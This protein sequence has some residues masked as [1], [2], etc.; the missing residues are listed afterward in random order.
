MGM[1]WRFLKV[2]YSL[3]RFLLL[4]GVALDIFAVSVFQ[5]AS[6]A[7]AATPRQ[8]PRVSAFQTTSFQIY[9]P[10]LSSESSGTT[11][12]VVSPPIAGGADPVINALGDI[13]ACSSKYNNRDGQL[14]TAALLGQLDGPILGLGDYV[15]SNGSPTYYAN[16][17]DPVWG[18]LKPRFYPAVGNHDY[19]TSKAAGYFGYFGAAAGDPSLGYYSFDL[20]QWHIVALNSNCNQLDSVNEC[21]AGSAQELWLRA[22]LAAHA[23]LCT[24]AF[25]HHPLY[26]SGKEGNAPRMHDIYQALI[27]YH[28]ELVINGH[29]HTYERFAPQD[30]N[31][32]PDPVNGIPEFVVGTGG[33]DHGRLVNLQPNSLI[34]DNTT[35]GVLRVVLHPDGYDYQFVPVAG[36]VFTDSGSGKCH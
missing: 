29:D 20:G 36:G 25:W 30:A 16:C 33:K 7:L 21:N 3:R 32:L 13:A 24:L 5:Q 15:Y 28:A 19:E 17:F 18:S 9:L 35:F 26:S 31:G 34:F 27:D 22:D 1:V 2:L 6:P 12:G 8:K 23:N 10:S 14:Q 4:A 11:G